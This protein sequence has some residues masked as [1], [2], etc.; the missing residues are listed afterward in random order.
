MYWLFLS[1]YLTYAFIWERFMYNGIIQKLLICT[2]TYLNAPL[3]PL[4][5]FLDN[6]IFLNI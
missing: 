5:N 2:I 3:L 4:E 1:K 6:T